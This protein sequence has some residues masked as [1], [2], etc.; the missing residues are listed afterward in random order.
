MVGETKA[1]G[2]LQLTDATAS[3]QNF[4]PKKP[5]RAGTNIQYLERNP[6]QHEYS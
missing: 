3:K 4:K 1:G 6:V 2:S 5:S